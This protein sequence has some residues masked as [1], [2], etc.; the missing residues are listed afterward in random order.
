MQCLTDHEQESGLHPLGAK[1][2]G[3]C[4]SLV[5]LR[6]LNL[7]AM[8]YTMTPYHPC[9]Q[10]IT[11]G[12]ASHHHQQRLRM[13]SFVHWLNRAH[14]TCP[15]ELLRW[16]HLA[17]FDEECEC[18][19]FQFQF[20]SEVLNGGT[21]RCLESYSDGLPNRPPTMENLSRLGRL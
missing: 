14:R 16:N 13:P 12:H 20:Q 6:L 8:L 3:K 21:F 2:W 7:R 10:A 9:F 5:Q 17:N 15:N 1:M 18:H 11:F 4:E 19:H